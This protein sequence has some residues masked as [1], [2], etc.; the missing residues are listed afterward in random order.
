MT[1]RTTPA[2]RTQIAADYAAG[3]PVAD[4]ARRYGRCLDTIY[5]VTARAGVR[6]RYTWPERMTERH[7]SERC[8]ALALVEG[9]PREHRAAALRLLEP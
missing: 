9:L 2:E 6:R 4:I 1:A 5:R 7:A 3:L 8:W